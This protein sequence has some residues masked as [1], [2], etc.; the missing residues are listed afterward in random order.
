MGRQKSKLSVVLESLGVGASDVIE[1]PSAQ[2]R[3]HERCIKS[4][5]CELGV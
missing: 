2:R 4:S 3:I 1:K 5:Q